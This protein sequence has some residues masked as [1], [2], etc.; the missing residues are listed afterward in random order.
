MQMVGE[1]GWRLSHGERSR[2]FL[3]WALLQQSDLVILDE[4][5]AALDPQTLHQCLNCTLDCAKSLL[6]IANP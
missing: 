1:T 4:S 3:A 6:V 5:F 2:L